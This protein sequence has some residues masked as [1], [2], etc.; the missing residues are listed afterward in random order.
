M[1]YPKKL[2]LAGGLLMTVLLHF[3][4]YGQTADSPENESGRVDAN[5]VLRPFDTIDF[6]MFQEPDMQQSLRLDADGTVI[7][8]LIGKQKIGGMTVE[9]AQRFLA[10]LYDK[11]YFVNPQISLL[12]TSFSPRT[13]QV[14]GQVN[15]QGPVVIPFDRELTLVDA[16]SS[17][18]GPTRL[19]NLRR[20]ALKRKRPDG[21]TTTFTLDVQEIMTEVD[22]ESFPL[23]DGDTIF[24]PERTF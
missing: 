3:S 20:V 23:Q 5:Y 22:V 15:K 14:L 9:Q 12:V 13:V 19:A 21:T 6:S 16:I 18:G 1:E 10:D 11:D 17:A 4:S 7:L 24:I 2:F 8:P